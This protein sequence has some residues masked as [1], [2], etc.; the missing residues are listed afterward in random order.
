MS[1]IFSA[2]KR[3]EIMS[4]IR[5]KNTKPELFVRSLLH[6]MGFRF[7]LHSKKLPGNPDI[8]LPKYKTVIFV[9]GCYWH[10]H[11]CHKGRSKP[12]SNVGTW[13][14]KFNRTVKRDKKNKKA[15][16]N[17]GWRVITVWQ[18]ELSDQDKIRR[19]LQK[20]LAR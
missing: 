8:C 17:L 5:S 12:L 16:E 14:L 19:M 7:R 20:A 11:V 1:D 10:R 18:C 2:E 4:R 15:L 9:H 3:S 6:K 13:K